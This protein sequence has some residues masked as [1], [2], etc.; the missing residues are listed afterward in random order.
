MKCSVC[1]KRLTLYQVFS[2]TPICK[3]CGARLTVENGSWLIF[4]S[5]L[6][7]VAAPVM[8]FYTTNV[9]WYIL[10]MLAVVGGV[11]LILEKV[12]KTRARAAIASGVTPR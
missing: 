9:G 4:F 3:S 11:L 2:V 1:Q 6:V 7:L 10:G 8:A 5:I 12:I